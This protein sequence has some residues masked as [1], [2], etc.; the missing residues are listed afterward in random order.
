MFGSL[1]R[2]A[3]LHPRP[4]A[5]VDTEAQRH[6]DALD[7]ELVRKARCMG[8]TVACLHVDEPG[9]AIVLPGH[10]TGTSPILGY[11]VEDYTAT[12][13]QLRGRGVALR[14]RE[15]PQG[16]CASFT[17]EGGQRYAVYDWSGLRRSISSTAASTRR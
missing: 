4:A 15:I 17:A 9:P 5:D 6:V 12:V 16:P 3:R 7:A 1:V 11:R 10:L 8:T 2:F 13:C 14:E